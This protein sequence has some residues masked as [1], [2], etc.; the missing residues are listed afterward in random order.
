MGSGCPVW[1]AMSD[2][3]KS[4]VLNSAMTFSLLMSSFPVLESFSKQLT[5]YNVADDL[6]FLMTLIGELQRH[7]VRLA[8]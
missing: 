6:K 8:N 2:P 7:N 1:R 5:I 3:F 4:A